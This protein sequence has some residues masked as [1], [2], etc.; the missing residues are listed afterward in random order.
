MH[1][2]MTSASIASVYVLDRRDAP[3]ISVISPAQRRAICVPALPPIADAACVRRQ[4][5][6][7]HRAGWNVVG[8]GLPGTRSVETRDTEA[9][10]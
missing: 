2:G 5:E 3:R 6:A 10:R 4:G 1:L 8:V 7:F 9:S